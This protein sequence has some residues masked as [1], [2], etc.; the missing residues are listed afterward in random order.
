MLPKC[1]DC[2]RWHWAIKHQKWRYEVQ[3]GYCYRVTDAPVTMQAYAAPCRD[4]IPKD[5]GLKFFDRARIKD[6][7]LLVDADEM[8]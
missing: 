3:S 1:I 7:D 6:L 8:L 5:N 2:A 4:F